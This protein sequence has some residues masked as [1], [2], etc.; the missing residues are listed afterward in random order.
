MLYTEVL[1]AEHLSVYSKVGA[2]GSL[3]VSMVIY[4]CSMFDGCAL[5][6]GL[7]GWIAVFSCAWCFV[8]QLDG[9]VLV[10]FWCEGR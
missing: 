1:W 3:W 8:Y 6:Q 2:H 9:N 5:L 7:D 10:A 4:D